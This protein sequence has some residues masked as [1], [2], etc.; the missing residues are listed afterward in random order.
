MTTIVDEH[1]AEANF[2]TLIERV[3]TGEFITIA[4][5][6]KPVAILLPITGP[7]VQRIPGID[8][9]R[10]VIAPDFDAPLAEFHPRLTD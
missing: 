2:L 5:A 6:G 10:V 1:E 7:P 8:A 3:M 9:G 4:R